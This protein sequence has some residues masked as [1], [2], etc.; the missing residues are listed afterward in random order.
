MCGSFFFVF[1]G[2]F[3]SDRAIGVA[4]VKLDILDKKCTLH[5][6]V[7]VS[8]NHFVSLKHFLNVVYDEI[9]IEEV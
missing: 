9:Y 5:E 6:V 7:Q 3:K 8:H 2:I 4:Q 1:S